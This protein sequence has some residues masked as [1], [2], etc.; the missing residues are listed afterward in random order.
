MLAMKALFNAYDKDGS[1]TLTKEELIT[2]INNS[3]EGDL[4][5]EEKAEI[6]ANIDEADKDKSG[7]LTVKEFVAFME[8]K[9]KADEGEK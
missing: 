5:E 9:V 1:G 6:I 4:S 2:A 7:E 3:K 8:L